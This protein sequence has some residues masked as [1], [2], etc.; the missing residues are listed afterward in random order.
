[1][2]ILEENNQFYKIRINSSV[3][4][5]IYGKSK[6]KIVL[7]LLLI[8]AIIGYLLPLLIM[9]FIIADDESLVFGYFISLL[10]FWGVSSYLLRLYLWNRYGREIFIINKE[11]LEHY[12]DY[13]L[14]K[15]NRKEIRYNKLKIYYSFEDK[16]NDASL[17]REEICKKE[18]S[19]II[20]EMDNNDIL[21]SRDCIPITEI[22][23][24]GKIV[25]RIFISKN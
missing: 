15:D 11:S 12:F 6:N 7:N 16:L 14:F 25:N 10:I 19:S 1:M 22:R 18:V 4:L 24:I 2:N 13:K 3:R 9:S 23:K 20:F 8:T 5:E 21:L 17:L